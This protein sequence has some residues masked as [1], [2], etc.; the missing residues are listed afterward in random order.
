M[1]FAERCAITVVVVYLIFIVLDFIHHLGKTPQLMPRNYRLLDVSRNSSLLEN[2]HN[3]SDV[4]QKGVEHQTTTQL[5]T[6]VG[7]K[8]ANT[9]KEYQYNLSSITRNTLTIMVKLISVKTKNLDVI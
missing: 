3:Y 2:Y 8:V 9:W 7:R 6:R 1:K 4:S 5:R